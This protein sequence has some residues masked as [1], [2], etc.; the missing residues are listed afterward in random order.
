[1]QSENLEISPALRELVL[2][3]CPQAVQVMPPEARSYQP[4]LAMAVFANVLGGMA[5]LLSLLLLPALIAAFVP[6]L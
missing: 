2:E 3:K 6:L 4:S 5:L 1:M